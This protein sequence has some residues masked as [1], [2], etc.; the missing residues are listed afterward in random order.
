MP[1]NIYSVRNHLSE[2][3]WEL[4][5]D[6]YKNLQT[7]LEMK[8]P[9]GHKIIKAYGEWRKH[10][11]CD[12]CMGGD[13]KKIKK[14]GV[15]AKGADTQRILALDAA[16]GITGYAFYDNG[17]LVGYGTFHTDGTKET[18]ARI[19]DV[20]H[21]L[22]GMLG[23]YEPDV[24]FLENI[25]LQKFGPN[26]S[27]A[28]VKTFQTLAQ[29]QGVLLDTIFEA[30]IDHELVYS[31][32]WRNYC[33]V[34]DDKGRENKKKAAQEKVKLWYGQDCTQDEADAICLGKYAVST[35]KKSSWGEGI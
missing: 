1:I 17:E 27:Q 4:I 21:W 22:T 20:K 6:T 32:T 26:A 5:S 34:G 35:M 25:Q 33:N 13:P 14:N 10:P 18:T 24:T 30:A 8:C 2:E 29:L 23:K 19:N 15:P 16:T 3:G 7:E 28:Q 12:E 11:I 31:S 9:K